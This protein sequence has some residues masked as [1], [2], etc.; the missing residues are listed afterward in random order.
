MLVGRGVCR[1]EPSSVC[2]MVSRSD[3][4][5]CTGK[6]GD[7]SVASSLWL[8]YSKVEDLIHL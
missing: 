1:F 3:E 8:S 2:P 5:K 7:S 6:A 4:E